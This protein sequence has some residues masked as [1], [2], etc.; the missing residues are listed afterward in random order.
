[1]CT[2]ARRVYGAR[3]EAGSSALWFGLLRMSALRWLHATTSL[4]SPPPL[5][6]T[7]YNALV[8]SILWVF[9]CQVLSLCLSLSVSFSFSLYPVTPPPLNT[10][11]SGTPTLQFMKA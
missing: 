7:L 5:S 6:Q 4:I 1:M 8:P 3:G 2:S 10:S 9:A 11:V